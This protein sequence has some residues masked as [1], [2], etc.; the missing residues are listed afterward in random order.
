MAQKKRGWIE[1]A[2][3]CVLTAFCVFSFWSVSD[4]RLSILRSRQSIEL[5]KLGLTSIA[6]E[7]LPRAAEIFQSSV[8]VEAPGFPTEQMTRLEAWKELQG[9]LSAYAERL[10]VLNAQGEELNRQLQQGR[11]WRS[12]LTLALA[13][14][15]MVLTVMNRRRMS[16]DAAA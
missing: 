10:K 12:Y 7:N 13:I 1:T 15:M 11:D 14:G 2:N 3:M 5:T 4:S 16:K 9:T 8:A 6:P